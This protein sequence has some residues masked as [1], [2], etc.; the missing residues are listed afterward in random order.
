MN[1]ADST[2]FPLLRFKEFDQKVSKHLFENIFLFTTGK[3]IK[4]KE[5]SPEFETPCVRYGELYHM[6]DEVINKVIN[7]T[8]LNK[9]ELLFSK[10]DEILLPSAGE[11]PL[12]IGS[13]SALTL[14][15]VAIGRTINI[16]RPLKEN[17][18]SQIFASYY[19]NQKLRRK[20]STL[21]KG[22]SISNVYNS[23]LKTLTI[24]L[25]TLPEQQKIASF[26]SAIDDKV[27]QLTKKK[28]LLEDYKKGVMQQLF[29]GQ[30]R[31]KAEDGKDYPD[32]EEKRL[33]DIT[34]INQGLQIAISERF[35]EPVEDGYFYITNEFLRAKS[36]KAFYIKSPPA[37]V[38]CDADDILMTRTGNTGQVVTGVNGAFH[39]NFFKIKYQD[40]CEKWFLYYFLTSPLTQHTILKLAG[41]STIPDLN[42]GDF[43]KIK[44]DLPSIKEQTKISSVVKSIDTKIESVT[45][46]ITQTQAFKKGLLQ[47]M[48]V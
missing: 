37:S 18:Y 48:F 21:A 19:I 5:A 8:N 3:N 6:Y 17:V 42:H 27:Q 14:E 20:I 16:L 32:W 2:V 44:I 39:N 30:L 24:N 26:L 36:E 41:T 34:K 43:Y 45:H 33:G 11:D 1:R 46:Q 13:A 7:K 38:I 22:S 4:Q 25:P 40:H 9:S 29:S 15:N 12:D 47:Q 10:G 31:F 28:A 23:D 35:L